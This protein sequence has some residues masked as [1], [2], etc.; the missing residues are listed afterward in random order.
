MAVVWSRSC[1]RIFWTVARLMPFCKAVAAKVWRRTC[2]GDVLGEAGA[3]GD[4]L[5]QALGPPFPDGE[6][7]PEGEVVLQQAPHSAGHRHDADLGLLAVGATFAPDPELALLPEDVLGGQVA[8][9][10]DAEAGVEQGPDDELLGGRV[11][12]VGEPVGLVG[13][14]GLADV[15]VGHLSPRPLRF[16]SR[17][18]QPL[19]FP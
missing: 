9:L 13:G 2:G 7:L 15:L 16:W 17:K 19:R 18:A 1:P 11:A 12:G 6:L 10:A 8:Q 4:L 5:D 14:E 3:V